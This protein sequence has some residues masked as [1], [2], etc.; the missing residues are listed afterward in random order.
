MNLRRLLAYRTLFLGLLVLATLIGAA[1]WSFDI[2]ARVMLGYA[3][4]T[5]LLLV[6]SMAAGLLGAAVL[7]GIRK[8]RGRAERRL[9]PPDP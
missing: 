7:V 8:L 3:L 6:A 4:I 9:P 1:V 2:E 5:L